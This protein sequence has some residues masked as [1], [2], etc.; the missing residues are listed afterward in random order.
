MHRIGLPDAGEEQ[1]ALAGGDPV[2][3]LTHPAPFIEAVGRQQAAALL[4]RL[5]E[6][7]LLGEGFRPCVAGRTRQVGEPGRGQPPARQVGAARTGVLAN[8]QHLVRRRNVPLRPPIRRKARQG[9][10]RRIPAEQ[11]VTTTHAWHCLVRESRTV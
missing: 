7:R 4:E 9:R 11:G 2:R 6:H 8:H 1:Q 3:T 5:A 10:Q